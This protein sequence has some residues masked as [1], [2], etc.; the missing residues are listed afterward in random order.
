MTQRVKVG[1]DEWLVADASK[2]TLMTDGLSGCVAIGIAAG[3]KIALAHVFSECSERNGNWKDYEAALDKAW[4][5]SGLKVAEGAPAHV[6]YSDLS[7]RWLAGKVSGW[8]ESKGLEVHESLAPGCAIGA[9]DGRG[10]LS[11]KSERNAA[12]FLAGYKTSAD[13]DAGVERAALSAHAHAAQPATAAVRDEVKAPP[14][15]LDVRLFD[16]KHPAHAVYQQILA[17]IPKELV[18]CETDAEKPTATEAR[19]LASVLT[20]EYL[21]H[22]GNARI[23]EIAEGVGPGEGTLFLST[24][25]P[26]ASG[27]AMSVKLEM[28]DNERHPALERDCAREARTLHQAN[29]TQAAEQQ[30]AQRAAP[31]LN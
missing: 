22:G 19:Q 2:T 8:L 26:L 13:A 15:E 10:D 16:A 27:H 18:N 12:Q 11:L 14:P 6:V 28:S 21:R 31:T 17:K 23:G 30:R 25:P 20:V 24:D 9:R 1:A 4:A 3:D 7:D 5:G 29:E